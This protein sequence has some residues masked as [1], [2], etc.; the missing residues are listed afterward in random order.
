MKSRSKHYSDLY[1]SLIS[2]IVGITYTYHYWWNFKYNTVF[3]HTF[4]TFLSCGL[5]AMFM[6]NFISRHFLYAQKDYIS[7]LT[8]NE[9]KIKAFGIEKFQKLKLKTSII[10][11]VIF[12]ITF[13]GLNFLFNQY[14]EYQLGKYGA[15]TEAKIENIDKLGYKGRPIITI[16]YKDIKKEFT[17]DSSRI[18][19][20]KTIIYSTK[21][22]EISKIKEY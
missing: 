5:F 1:I 10:F 13:I 17:T 7:S 22:P 3:L 16:K 4:I 18:E 20:I 21:H 9:D 11:I 6:A 2:I 8:I 14:T 15:E 12:V 19:M